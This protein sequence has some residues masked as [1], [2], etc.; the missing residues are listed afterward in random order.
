MHS[1]SFLKGSVGL[2]K[3]ETCTNCFSGKRMNHAVL[4][5]GYGTERGQDYW[6]IKNSW[7]SNWG[8]NGYI[9]LARGSNQCGLAAVS[10]IKKELES[11]WYLY[12]IG[13]IQVCVS[14]DCEGNG[15]QE[16]APTTPKPPPVPTSMRCDISRLFRGRKDIT[17]TFN[18]RVND[19]NTGKVIESEVRCKNS[20]CTP[21]VPGPS[22]A[23]MYICGA[24]KC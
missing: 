13:N 18:L 24:L 11:L 7:G 6:L 3:T 22:N 10:K 16:Y 14:A 23:C 8:L 21:K 9:K 4:V 17:G 15:S 20:I 19:K 5:V 2:S 1:V 12:I